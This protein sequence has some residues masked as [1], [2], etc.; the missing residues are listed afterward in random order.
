MDAEALS[1][2]ITGALFVGLIRLPPNRLLSKLKSLLK[3]LTFFGAG[4]THRAAGEL[5]VGEAAGSGG[6]K[7]LD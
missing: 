6:N 1:E 4:A 7:L 3:K 5:G 2:Q